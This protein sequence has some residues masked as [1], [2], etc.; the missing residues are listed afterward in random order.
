MANPG[1]SSDKK[2]K[3]NTKTEITLP[4]T[5][6]RLLTIPLHKQKAITNKTTNN[7]GITY[8]SPLADIH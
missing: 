5:P 3:A 7:A 1:I 2:K 8:L 6:I 4:Q